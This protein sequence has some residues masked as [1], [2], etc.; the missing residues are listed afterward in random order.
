MFSDVEKGNNPMLTRLTP[1]ATL[2]LA[3]R[4]IP[5]VCAFIFL[6]TRRATSYD[7]LKHPSVSGKLSR[8]CPGA[9]A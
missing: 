4:E 8:S 5:I 6:A 1:V 9:A 2:L 7:A 3:L